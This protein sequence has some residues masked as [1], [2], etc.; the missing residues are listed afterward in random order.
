MGPSSSGV[1]NPSSLRAGHPQSTASSDMHRYINAQARM[2]D[3]LSETSRPIAASAWSHTFANNNTNNN[4]PLDPNAPLEPFTP[5]TPFE[6]G[7]RRQLPQRHSFDRLRQRERERERDARSASTTAN[8]NSN[9]FRPSFPPTNT[10]SP[11]AASAT[12]ATA[13]ARIAFAEQSERRDERLMSL[14]AH[15]SRGR[16]A[17]FGG[18]VG[19]T[20]TGA[21][22]SSSNTRSGS[23]AFPSASSNVPPQHQHPLTLQNFQH[24]HSL[25]TDSPGWAG[26]GGDGPGAGAR[27][28]RGGR[29]ARV[30]GDYMVSSNLF[31]FLLDCF[32]FWF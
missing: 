12:T 11:A 19:G 2:A 28:G 9:S 27:R 21:S 32:L 25:Q 4:T 30:L 29:A 1:V 3:A 24:W 22:N 8:P 14:Q 31:I 16:R 6:A 17:R 23:G 15:M 10:A 18:I 20:A 7:R 26:G 13:A 5:Y